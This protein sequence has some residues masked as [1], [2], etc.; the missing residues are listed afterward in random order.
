MTTDAIAHIAVIGAGLMDTA[1]HR[2][3]QA[4]AT[5]SVYTMSPTNTSKP[6]APT[7]NKI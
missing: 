5:L 1:S 3:L 4:Q 6:R 7:L 2:N